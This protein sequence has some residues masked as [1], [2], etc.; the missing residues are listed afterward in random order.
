MYFVAEDKQGPA[1]I[2]LEIKELW[3]KHILGKFSTNNLTENQ[4]MSSVVGKMASLYQKQKMN[5]GKP[6]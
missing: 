5:T 2:Y 1:I 6:L 4:K 3:L